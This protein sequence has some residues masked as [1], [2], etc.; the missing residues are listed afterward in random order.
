[1]LKRIKSIH[2][3]AGLSAILALALGAVLYATGVQP[4]QPARGPERVVEIKPFEGDS[5]I[6]GRNFPRQYDSWLQTQK[7][8]QTTYGGSV[9]FDRLERYSAYLTLF[10]GNPFSKD[11]DED[12]GHFWSLEDVRTTG[13]I[14]EKSP[15]TCY[16]CKS[17]N[18]PGVINEMGAA[19]FYKAPFNDETL[20]AKLRHPV[21]CADC[22][23]PDTMALV[24]TRPALAEALAAQGVD[25]TKSSRQEMRTLVC[26]QCHVEYYFAGEG[27]Y[28]TFPWKNGLTIEAI[29]KYYDDLDFK[30]FT[31]AISGADILK[32]QHPEYEL[33]TGNS[34]HY[35]AGVACADCHMP[36]VRDGAAKYSSHYVASPLLYA[37]Q[38]CGACHTDVNYVTGRV[39]TIQ[40]QTALMLVAAEDAL[41]QAINSIGEAA[42]DVQADTV[43]LAEAWA[44]HRRAQLRWDFISAENSTGFH[45]PEEALR[46]LGEAIKFAYQAELKAV[47]ARGK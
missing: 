7:Q 41:V 14:T 30:D 8:V 21:G 22:H 17:A 47:A 2:I 13:R 39:A 15:A 32:M 25:W 44:L 24:I 40:G 45:N 34:T 12:R 23:D 10:A 43:L 28:L 26:A 5:A 20:A 27:K 42:A 18:V 46:I 29:E 36:Y 33:Y 35:V 4:P 37:T 3:L 38:A 11:Y 6:W 31:H 16:T 9:D 19:E 1:M